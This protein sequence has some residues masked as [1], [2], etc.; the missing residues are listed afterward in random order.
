MKQLLGS[1]VCFTLMASFP[2]WAEQ[3]KPDQP[4]ESTERGAWIPGVCPPF[5]LRDESGRVINPRTGENADQPY[6][7]KQTCGVC[8]DYEKITQGYHFTQGR[9]EPPTPTQQARCN[10]AISP[11]NFGGNWCSPAPLYRYLSPKQN[12]S[13]AVIDMTAFTFFTSPCGTCHPGGGPAEY[14]RDGKR[15][16]QWMKDPQSGFTPGGDNNLDGDYYKA[17]WSETGVL[18]ADCL[19]CHLPEYNYTE[20]NRQ[21]AAWNFRWAAAAGAGFATVKGSVQKKESVT[22]SYNV[23]LFAEDGTLDLHI[24][25]EPR[26]EACLNCHAQP[27][28]KKRGS[29]F[30]LR[31]DVHLRAGLKCVDCH[32]AGSSATDPR[33]AGKEMHEIAKGDDPGGLIRNDLDDTVVSCQDCH[34]TGKMGAPIA[35]HLWLPPLHLENIACQTCHIPE[36]MVMPIEVQASDVYNSAP[37]IDQPAKRLWTFYGPDWKFRNHY[38]FLHMMG[39]ED[40]PTEVFR[41]KLVRYKGKIYPAN[42]VHSA[43]PG[44]EIEGQTALMQP[45]MSDIVKMWTSHFQ[46]P[47]KNFPE[48]AKIKDDNNDGIP[49]VN[50][51][52]EIDA[53]ISSVTDMLKSIDYPLDGKRVVWVMDDRVYRSGKEYC[54]M[55]KEPWEKSPFANVHKYSHDILPAKA[56]IGTNGCTDCHR[57]DSSFFFAPVLVHLF[58]EHARPVVEPQYVQLGLHGNTVLLTAW[59]QAYLKPAIYGLLLLLPVPLLALIG[60]ATLAWRFPSQSLPRGLRLIPIL[61]AIGSLVVVVSLL[62]HPDLLEYVLPGR[63]WLDANHFIVASGVMAIGLVALL[64][65][66]KQLFV[67][68]DLRSVMGMV[69]VV[70]GG[71]SLVASVLSGLFMLFKL[72]ALELVTRLSYSIFDGAIGLLLIVTL[73]VLIRQIAAWYR[74]TR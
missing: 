23:D 14:D 72:R 8:H 7:P 22:L 20:R 25:R 43:W 32:P 31:T 28:W 35:R 46:D 57:P 65:E 66:V 4:P 17:F 37:K 42:Q 54:T 73:V 51:A 61:L 30:S 21:L 64:W 11:G 74:P 38:G 45:R 70:V 62:Y 13:P 24:V 34:A 6:S 71:L 52:E 69:L 55:E 9:G 19:L 18:E 48:L 63:M 41:P 26:N 58:D 39:Y 29:N 27:G 68:Q 59:S 56:A 36:R 60:Q 16:D 47:K 10:W 1:I 2:C 12:T 53:L 67:P 49:E 3:V 5:P 15:Y 50:T 40:K 33:I 44:I